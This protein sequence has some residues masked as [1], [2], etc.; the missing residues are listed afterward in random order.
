MVACFIF[1]S[2][3][4]EVAV[5][6]LHTRAWIGARRVDSG[7]SKFCYKQFAWG[8]RRTYGAINTT[9][10]LD[11]HHGF[12]PSKCWRYPLLFPWLTRRFQSPPSLKSNRRS[13]WDVNLW[14]HRM[15]LLGAQE[16][17]TIG[18]RSRLARPLFKFKSQAQV[19]KEWSETENGVMNHS[20]W[21]RL[22]E[23]DCL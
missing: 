8:L 18:S 13:W 10:I 15:L 17:W 2:N 9:E 19:N 6:W 3:R 11:L 23:I 7:Q 21:K 5:L 12:Q 22:S 16:S 20:I 1:K 14:E 4:L